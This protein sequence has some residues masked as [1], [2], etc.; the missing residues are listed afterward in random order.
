MGIVVG[1]DATLSAVGVVAVDRLFEK[2][3]RLSTPMAD[4]ERRLVRCPTLLLFVSHKLKG[5]DQRAMKSDRTSVARHNQ[6]LAPQLPFSK[7]TGGL[8]NG[9][10]FERR[11][12]DLI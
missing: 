5:K 9:C 10:W 4:G 7:Y 6:A 11:E 2:L 1:L 12:R 8:S 3:G